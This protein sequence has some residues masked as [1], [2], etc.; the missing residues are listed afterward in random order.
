MTPSGAFESLATIYELSY[1][2]VGPATSCSNAKRIVIGFNESLQ[3]T[4]FLSMTS[5]DLQA[6]CQSGTLFDILQTEDLLFIG[7]WGNSTYTDPTDWI[8]ISRN[9]PSLSYVSS[10]KIFASACL[11]VS[12]Q[13]GLWCQKNFCV[14]SNNSLSHIGV[15]TNLWKLQT[16]SGAT[17]S[18]SGVVNSV[19]FEFLTGRLG[20]VFNPQSK[21]VAARIRYGTTTSATFQIVMIVF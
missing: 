17:R 21:I 7:Q 11:P 9:I 10:H 3:S 20:S 2:D 13:Y 5:S 16:W 6:A 14:L 4:C 1:G 12:H 19:N 15:F 18:C 8:Q